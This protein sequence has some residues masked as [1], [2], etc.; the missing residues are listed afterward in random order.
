MK[1]AKHMPSGYSL[2][3]NCSFDS[4]E[5]KPDCYKAEDC[6]ERF[7]KDLREHAMKIINYEKKMI[8]LNDEVNKSYEE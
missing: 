4:T 2:F 3:R 5:K 8:P 6:M 1:K 7:C